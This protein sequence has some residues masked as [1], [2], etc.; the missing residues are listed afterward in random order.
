MTWD[1]RVDPVAALEFWTK[2]RKITGRK[3]AEMYP[4]RKW[5]T[6]N[7][8]IVMAK[9]WFPELWELKVESMADIDDDLIT[10]QYKESTEIL[11]DGSRRS[12]KLLEMNDEQSKDPLYLLEAHGFDPDEW[13]IVTAKNNIW[14][15]YSKKADGTG[16]DI[17]TLYSSRITVKPRV[18][19]FN[20]AD[21]FEA[22]KAAVTPR[23]ID[24]PAEG[25]RMLELSYTDMHMGNSTAEWYAG[26]LERSAVYI[27]S[28]AWKQIVVWVGSDLFHC[29]NFK[30]TTSNG[31]PQSSVWW[32]DAVKDALEF[33]GTILELALENSTQVVVYYVPGNHDES[34]AWLFALLLQEKYP[35]IVF[36]TAIEERKVHVFGD[37]AIGMTHG[38]EKTRKDLD[39][40]FGSQFPE[41]ASAKFR[42][43]HMGHLHHEEVIDRFGVITRSLPTAARTDKWHREQGFVGASKVFQLFEWDEEYGIRDVHYV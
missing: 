1:A 32:P 12:D 31:T 42:E 36:D 17:S 30:N 37:C 23:T 6:W 16:H 43:V 41:F 34:M 14:N 28:R 19:Q 15:V 18:V 25:N 5:R 33:L 24:Q 7:D 35:Q 9:H 10:K 11:K 39:R 4:E 13:E 27:R 3:L 26:T 2:H 38:D 20:A 29:D 21:L 40:V 22:V 8:R